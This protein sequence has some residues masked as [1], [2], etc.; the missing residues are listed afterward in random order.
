[1]Y[2]RVWRMSVLPENVEQFAAD[3][4]SGGVVNHG[5]PGYRG[6]LVLRGGPLD[7][8]DATVV[9]L[10]DSLEALRASESD[11]FQKAVA[12]V[13][14]RCKPGA[15]LRE[16]EILTWEMPAPSKKSKPKPK[17]KPK[18]KSK[19]KRRIKRRAS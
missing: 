13:L 9:S 19:K 10:W 15:M 14:A 1:M 17:S 3:C 2:A 12:G 7:S 16:E 5:Q 11:A 18:L 4:R 8:P 6:L